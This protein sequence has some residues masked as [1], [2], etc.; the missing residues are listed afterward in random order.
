MEIATIIQLGSK[1]GSILDKIISWRSARKALKV[2]A[3]TMLQKAINQTEIYLELSGGTYLPNQELSDA[4]LEII[5][6]DFR[7]TG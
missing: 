3:I 1:G 4:W 2:H 6:P 5:L 7:A